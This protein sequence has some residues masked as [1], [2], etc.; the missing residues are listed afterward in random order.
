MR[1]RVLQRPVLVTMRMG[2]A[3]RLARRMDMLL[4]GI[5]L[6]PVIVFDR[7]MHVQMTMFLSQVRSNCVIR[8]GGSGS[9]EGIQPQFCSVF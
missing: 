5:V 4:V 2:S 8:T 3:G 6:V 7:G 9:A 1:V